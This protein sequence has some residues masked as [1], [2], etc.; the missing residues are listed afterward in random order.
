[1]YF[2]VEYS[3]DGYTVSARSET[4]LVW[5]V[6]IIDHFCHPIIMQQ[7]VCLSVWTGKM[8]HAEN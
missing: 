3:R 8:F 7:I 2:S 5:V 1:M 6:G 4:I